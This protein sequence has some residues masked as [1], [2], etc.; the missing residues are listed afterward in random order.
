MHWT[1][2][3]AGFWRCFTANAKGRSWSSSRYSRA[4]GQAIRVAVS[5]AVSPWRG[6]RAYLHGCA[7]S[8]A[9]SDRY[10][11]PARDLISLDGYREICGAAITCGASTSLVAS[12]GCPFHNWCAKPIFGNKFALEFSDFVCVCSNSR[13]AS[14]TSGLPM[15]SLRLTARSGTRHAALPFK[16]QCRADLLVPANCSTP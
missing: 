14:S 1:I 6:K 16:I 9:D 8:V 5:G 12:R 2:C 11:F 15:T 4:P 3:A 13:T 7:P 10:P